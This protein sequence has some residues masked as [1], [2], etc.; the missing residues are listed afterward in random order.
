MDDSDVE[1]S[2]EL[3]RLL[4]VKVYLRGTEEDPKVVMRCRWTLKT[5][6]GLELR[7]RMKKFKGD[8]LINQKDGTNG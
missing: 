5:I 7:Q 1:L 2:I 6:G 4:G 8:A 3:C